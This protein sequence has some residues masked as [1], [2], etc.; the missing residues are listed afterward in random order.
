ME[1]FYVTIV[2]DKEA[3]DRLDRLCGRLR[4]GNRDVVAE[5]L[6]DLEQKLD[7]ADRE[8]REWNEQHCFR[9]RDSDDG[10]PW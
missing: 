8:F 2:L 7:E 9:D 6:R 4:M 3:F 5:A 1:D 10:W